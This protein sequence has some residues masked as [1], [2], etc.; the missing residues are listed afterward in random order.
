MVGISFLIT[1]LKVVS[2]G[3]CLFSPRSPDGDNSSSCPNPFP[4][5]F[6]LR[7]SKARELILADII[8]R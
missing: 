6:V 8:A 2:S 4:C 5:S 7:D 1:Y 3:N